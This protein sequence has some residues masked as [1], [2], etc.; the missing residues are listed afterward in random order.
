M[1]DTKKTLPYTAITASGTELT[2]RFPL[3]PLT[4]SEEQVA[5][6]LTCALAA[7][8]EVIAEQASVSDGDI[9]QALAMALA[10]RTRMV[11]AAHGPVHRLAKELVASSLGAR[12]LSSDGT[13]H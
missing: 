9:M 4:E 12:S 1:A 8:D 2:F 6:L 13:V 7:I 10:I 5:D 11:E 3:H